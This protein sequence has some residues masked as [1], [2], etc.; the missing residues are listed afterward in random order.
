MAATDKEL[1]LMCYMASSP[2]LFAVVN[3]IVKPSYFEP[4]FFN[5]IRFMQEYYQEYN[6]VPSIDQIYAESGV[7]L[8]KKKIPPDQFNYAIDEIESF[9]RKQ[10]ITDAILTSA[11]MLE[12]GDD[13]KIEQLVR[14]AV[15]TSIVRQLGLTV[16]ENPD[17]IFDEI[18][19]DFP[20]STK[21]P[22]FDETL[23]GGI[24]RK[25]LL[26]LMANSGVGKS[27]TMYNLAVNFCSQGLNGIILSLELYTTTVM[28]RL[29][30]MI[31]LIPQAELGS[32]R[33]EVSAAIKSYRDDYGDLTVT[34]MPVG[35]NA[36]QIRAYIK[37]YELQKGFLP[38][39]IVLDYLDLMAPM[40]KVSA[41]NVFEKDKR[42]SEQ[43]RQILVDYNMIGVTASQQNRSSVS[44]NVDELNHSHIAGGISKINTTDIAVS[45]VMNDIMRAA[46]DIAF[47]FLK[48]RSSSGVGTTIY[49][50]WDRHTLTIYNKKHTDTTDSE[51]DM[52]P[53]TPKK[54]TASILDAFGDD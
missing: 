19:D 24:R 36:A 53:K 15:N 27:N 22:D 40:E 37:E 23:G 9:C 2:E 39:F 44:V 51:P 45:I 7:E 46:G 18:F 14:D 49:K 8:V 11:D 26:L 20:I 1:L 16:F 25:E 54:K 10:A 52:P 41:D 4:E 13:T 30:S 33:N 5:A 34:H 28:K 32:R 42:V 3:S 6:A 35:T 38:D 12:S 29:A 31:T 21:W 50:G 47:H 43:L 48:T 17:V